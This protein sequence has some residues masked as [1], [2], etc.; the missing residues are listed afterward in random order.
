[1]FHRDASGVRI[2]LIQDRFGRWSLPKGHLEEGETAV[3]A[4]LR[5]VEEETG[6]KGV[7]RAALPATRY[8]FH[9]RGELV[10]KTVHYFLIEA[11]GGAARPQAGEIAAVGW[12]GPDEVEGLAHYENN[13]P[14]LRAALDLI[15]VGGGRA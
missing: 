4:A 14:V 2:L 9:D 8:F 3:Q 15:G 7:V 13:R 5:E 11:A 12:F 6:I 10:E 1:M